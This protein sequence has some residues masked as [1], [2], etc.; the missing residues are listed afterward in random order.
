[1]SEAAVV[2]EGYGE[3]EA[4]M[5][6]Y[7]EAGEARARALG[8]RGPIRFSAD[9]SLHPDIAEAYWKHGFYV[10]EG[11]IG[12]DELADIERDVLEILDRAPTEP[13]GKVDRHGRPALASDG[14]GGGMAMVRP[15]SDPIGGTDKNNGRHPAKMI[16]PTPPADSPEWILQ[17]VGGS[18]Q[19]S[20]AAL[21]LYAHPDLLAVAA[22]FNGEDFSPFNEV[23]WIKHPRLGG[24]VAWHQD[25][26]THWDT[27]KFHRGSHGFNFMAQ[28]YGCNAANGLWVVPGSHLGK[29]DIRAWCEAA[30]SDRLP[31]AVPII[32][33]P[34]DVAVTNR[35]AVHGS[36]ANTS[37][38]CRVTINFGFHPRASVIGAR[39]NGIH[40]P[41]SEKVIYDEDRVRQRS[42]VL[43]LAI[44]ARRQR[45]PDE[46]PYDYQPLRGQ[47][48]EWN[49]TARESLRGYNLLDLGI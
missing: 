37:D 4:A 16:E 43:G 22:E 26:T 1:M 48:F 23:I 20:D 12:R 44:E 6:A 27:P 10:F 39:G 17:V 33:D 14:R 35:Q 2:S 49:D 32:C 28:L 15:L 29:A 40:A 24:S 21:R 11:V 47:V 30:G 8:N 25:G 36:F 19:F 31:D 46:T 45:F 42:R 41:G 7:R 5:L 9:G 34:G 3:H 13:G 38:Q 18:L